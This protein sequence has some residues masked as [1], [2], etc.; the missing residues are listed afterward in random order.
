MPPI[1]RRFAMLL[2]FA[3]FVAHAF[4]SPQPQ[5]HPT[6]LPF[7]TRNELCVHDCPSTQVSRDEVS[8]AGT[9]TD[10]PLE[11]MFDV[12]VDLDSLNSGDLIDLG[13][14]KYYLLDR[15]RACALIL[16]KLLSVHIHA[17]TLQVVLVFSR[18]IAI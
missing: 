10:L 5:Q 8:L 16:S 15:L 3:L 14:H 13:D 1:I 6:A 18:I 2:S 17:N 4:S 11:P 12:L 9:E 7:V